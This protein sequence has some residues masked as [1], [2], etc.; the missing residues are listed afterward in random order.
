MSSG[1]GSSTDASCCAARKIRL[2]FSSACSS[3]RV[4]EGLPMTNGII[5]C[6]KTTTSRRGTIGRVSYTSN[7]DSK[8]TGF[9]DQGN[10]F[11]LRHHDFAGDGDFADL[12]L[13]RH[14]IHQVEHQLF[15]DHTEA[16]RADLAFERRFRNRFER[17]VGEAELHVLVLEEFHVLTRDRV[18]RLREDLDERGAIEL[19]QRADDRQAADELGNQAV[20]DQILRLELF[21]RRADLAAAD[22]FHIR[23]EAER[24][25]ADAAVDRLVEADERAAADE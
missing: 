17:V 6:G 25:L 18:A 3:A 22:R 2:S 24:L 15:D 12:L 19:V 20:L 10:G 1:R 23:L 21:E 16:A 7:E 9:L 13:I 4:D 11:V 5:M 8:L 14:L